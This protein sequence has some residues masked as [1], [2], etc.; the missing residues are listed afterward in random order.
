M[1]N[2]YWLLFILIIIISSFIFSKYTTKSQITDTTIKVGILS[3]PG[4]GALFVGDA[5]GFFKEEGIDLKI[6]FIENFDS[7]RSALISGQIDVDYTTID[8]VLIYNEANFN[9]QIFGMCDMSN[10]ADG[11]VVKN[12]IKTFEDLKGKTIAY[13]EASPNEFVLR[14]FLKQNNMSIKDV[15]LKPV[16][17]AQIAGN[18]ILA[19]QVDAA[20]TFEPFL[21][22]SKEN[23]NLHIL[24]SSKE[25]PE[26]I[27][28]LFVGRYSDLEKRKELYK[29][30]MT[31]WGQTTDYIKANQQESFEIISKK[32]NLPMTA[33]QSI[34]EGIKLAQSAENKKAFDKSQPNNLYD[35]I[36]LINQFWIESGI[37]KKTFYE[38]T[39]INT[40]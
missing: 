24:S 21:T 10:G 16:A 15:V 13:G 22:K 17:D 20:V 30:F 9:A 14:Y 11:I 25:Y 26:L 35:L 7:R 36:K 37:I 3:W 2:K 5:K 29:K 39:L 27:P 18:C 38:N 6:Q 40:L 28:G 19:E 23:K 8:Q 32:M 12:E 33:L 31:A 1:K 34:M 4:C